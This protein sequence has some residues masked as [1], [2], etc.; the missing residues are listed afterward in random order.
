LNKLEAEAKKKT[1]E[2]LK[3]MD[4]EL[5]EIENLQDELVSKL[6]ETSEGSPTN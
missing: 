5:D 3:K 1:D 2:T 6:S 4:S